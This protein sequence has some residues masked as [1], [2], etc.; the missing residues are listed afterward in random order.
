MCILP[1][2]VLY[3]LVSNEK[4]ETLASRGVEKE[5][6]FILVVVE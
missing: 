4:D 1:F 5:S 2:G 6:S 3:L